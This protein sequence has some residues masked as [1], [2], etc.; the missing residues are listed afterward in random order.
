MN[1]P[2]SLY[3]LCRRRG[4]ARWGFTLVEIMTALGVFSLLV[5]GVLYSQ[6]FGMRMFN[7]TS[8]RLAASDN[9]RKVLNAVRYDVLSGKMLYVGNGSSAGF[10]NIPG[11]GLR[12]GNALQIHPTT[13][14]NVFILYYLDP[15]TGALSRMTNGG[16]TV[17]VLASS[18]TNQI[19]FIAEDFEGN[20]LANDQNNRVIRV[21]LDFYQ[22]QSPVAQVGGGAGY[23]AYQLQT[24]ITRRAID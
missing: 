22:W 2:P 15:S 13:D 17:Q 1:L 20:I 8:A 16:T 19:A 7:L 11:N 6:L 10:T 12:Q 5:M 18:L 23:E 3:S 24:R 4:G 9:A 14:T 21:V